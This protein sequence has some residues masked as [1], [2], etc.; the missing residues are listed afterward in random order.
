MKKLTT[1]SPGSV[2]A[3]RPTVLY[4]EDEAE[5]FEVTELRLGKRYELLWARTDEEAC[6]LVKTRGHQ[7]SAV[8][9]DI[10]LKG[11]ALDGMQLTKLLRGRPLDVVLPP[12]AQGLPVLN[13]P[14]IVV[15]AFSARYK[16]DDLVAVGANHFVTKPVDFV[17]LSLALAAANSREVIS[18]LAAAPAR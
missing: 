4:V 2:A 8:L 11:S 14:V 12:H 9:M 3:P 10:Q 16:E 13:V 5:N 1:D 15:T 6:R 17:K 18:R 7:L